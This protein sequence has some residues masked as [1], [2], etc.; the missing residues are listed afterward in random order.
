MLRATKN[1]KLEEDIEADIE[2]DIEDMHII[3]ISDQTY[4]LTYF[5]KRIYKCRVPFLE[6]KRRAIF[7]IYSTMQEI[8]LQ[9]NVKLKFKWKSK[10][11]LTFRSFKMPII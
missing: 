8:H 3:N 11:L 4:Q 10:D 2:E 9:R 5:L 1:C 7:L 6:E